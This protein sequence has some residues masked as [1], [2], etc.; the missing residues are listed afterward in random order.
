VAM[1]DKKRHVPAPLEALL[2]VDSSLT[3][4]FCAVMDTFLPPKQCRKFYKYFELS[5]HGILW[6]TAWAGYIFLSWNSSLFEM[7]VNL[8]LGLLLDILAITLLKAYVRRRR[9]S[10]HKDDMWFTM[11][12]D[13]Y[14]FPSGHVSRASLITIFFVTIHP[15]G[16]FMRGVLFAWVVSIAVSRVLLRRHFLIDVL[17]GFLLSFL[18]VFL[19]KILWVGPETSSSIVKFLTNSRD[20]DFDY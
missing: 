14:S 17:G 18:E 16:A 12:V 4:A 3:N 2:R 9:P 13:Q 15:V 19:L 6:L 20:A 10:G 8:F 11:S 1:S 5:C 7:Q